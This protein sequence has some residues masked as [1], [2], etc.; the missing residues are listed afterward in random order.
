M[1]SLEDVLARCIEDIQAGRASLADCLERYPDR[2]GE[3][4]P[5]LKIA[6]SIEPPPDVRPS[7]AFRVRARVNLMEHIHATRPAGRTASRTGGGRFKR[8]V[9]LKPVTI[10]MAVILLLGTLGTGTAFAAQDSLPGDTLYPAKIGTEQLQRA[11]T[12]DEDD[13]VALEL[14]FAGT[15]LEE[16]G[17][18]AAESP[19]DAAVAAAGYQRNLER[20]LSLSERLEDGTARAGV[21]ETIA[22]TTAGHLEILDGLEDTV[23]GAVRETIM[24]TRETAFNG[25]RGALTG[26]A[27]EDP[28]KATEINLDTTGGRLN[29]AGNC[30]A[31]DDV[32]GTI[33]ALN[34]FEMLNRLGQEIYQ[35]ALQTGMDTTLIRQMNNRAAAEHLTILN[36]IGT[37]SSGEIRAAV[38]RGIQSSQW[39]YGQTDTEQP[40]G[41]ETGPGTATPGPDDDKPGGSQGQSDTSGAS[42]S[43]KYGK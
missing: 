24:N 36:G 39:R 27:T 38:E 30:A 15:R 21:M 25:H 34:Q 26:L 1:K 28:E 18:V 3:L 43:G 19:D 17:A 32:E 22:L 23:P 37:G 7:D 14:K 12:F 16:M 8:A 41:D 40:G 31:R 10:S 29:R 33:A 2:R 35:T 4:E 6:L 11:L 5:L 20:A 13:G 9:W 42:G